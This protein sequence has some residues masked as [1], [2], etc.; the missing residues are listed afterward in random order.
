[1]NFG[2]YYAFI[3]IEK[4]WFEFND[5]SCFPCEKFNKS[6]QTAYILVYQRE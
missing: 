6:S 2:H 1:M 4:E 3:N 5:S